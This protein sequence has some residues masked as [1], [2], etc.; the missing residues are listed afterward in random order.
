MIVLQS[1][2]A[3]LIAESTA[4]AATAIPQPSQG[5]LAAAGLDQYPLAPDSQRVDLVAPSFPDVPSVTNPLFPVSNLHSVVS[6][7]VVGG[8]PFRVEVTLLPDTQILEWI[9]GQRVK[10]L[11]SQ[12][13]AYSDGRI[14]E[15]AVDLYAQGDDGSVWY[16]GEEV[17]DYR[18]GVVYTTGGTWRAGKEGPLSMIMPGDPH[19]GDVH[20]AENIPGQSFEELTIDRIGVQVD[21]PRGPVQGAIVGRELHQDGT[22]S[23]KTFAPGYGEFY[24]ANDG[25]VEALALAVPTDA[26]PGPAPA[27]LDTLTTGAGAIFD[28]A[29]AKQWASVPNTLLAMNTAWASH[30]ATGAVPL[31]LEEPTDLALQKL[32][33][34]A[35]GRNRRAT[36]QRSLDM[37]LASLDLQ[38]QFHAVTDVDISRFELW[39]RRVIADAIVRDAANVSG[40]IF[41]LE[42]I[43]DRFVHVLDKVDVT[44]IDTLLRDLRDFSDDQDLKGATATAAALR[45][46]LAEIGAGVH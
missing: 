4:R 3:I 31:R 32:T 18:D 20:R 28:A 38:L 34:V 6:N 43:R 1:V 23:E 45:T 5:Q 29:L 16:L 9:A 2:G 46:K 19:V 12:Y 25:E 17:S 39:C 37:L 44:R 8:K 11:V 10:V 21:G 41:T 15:V 33:R 30:R 24:T 42:W 7:G 26:L 40:D 22:F 13:F 27:A 35:R 14:E 36:L